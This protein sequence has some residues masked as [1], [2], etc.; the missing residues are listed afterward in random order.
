MVSSV[1]HAAGSTAFSS[2]ADP[3]LAHT[4]VDGTRHVFEIAQACRCTDWHL[5]STAYVCGRCNRADE[6]LAS[7]QPAFRNDY[8]Q[9]KW[10][11]E[12]ETQHAAARSGASLTTYRPSV[13]VGNSRTGATT[14]FA[15]IHRV[16]RAVALLARAAEQQGGSQRHRIPLRIPAEA[17]AR[18]NLIFVDDVA[19]EF[20]EIFAQPRARGCIFHLT[21]PNPPSNAAIQKAL[22]EYYNIGGGR[23]VGTQLIPRADRT[24]YEDI[25]FDVLLDTEPYLLE[26]PRFDRTQ[27]DR[28]VSR[29]P[30]TWGAQR[31]RQQIHFGETSGWRRNNIGRGIAEG[32]DGGY[33]A[34]FERFVPEAHP[35]F[36]LSSLDS[37]D[38][39]VRFMIGKST[40]GDWT[41][42]YR[43]GR[44]ASVACAN[45]IAANVTYRITPPTFW[46]IVSGRFAASEAFLSGD[47]RITGDIERGLKFAMILQEFV[48]EFPYERPA[49]GLHG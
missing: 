5:V 17:H 7:I 18:P 10:T 13:I 1:V 15:G 28:F 12:H 30:T 45:G 42:C 27:T 23:F 8:E 46:S 29:P 24:V 31:L 25:F 49:D 34:Y 37:L 3:N 39:N 4:N 20:A 48:R 38:L 16:F 40:D 47:V 9:T 44:L 2:R 32:S 26:S 6:V 14:R 36:R 41:C 21:H 35:R 22:E 43:G 11:A 33:S 19:R